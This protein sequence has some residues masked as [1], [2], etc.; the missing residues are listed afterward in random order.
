MPSH[1]DDAMKP[2]MPSLSRRQLLK[3]GVATGLTLLAPP[4]LASEQPKLTIPPLLDVGRGRPIRLDF[5]LT[6]TRLT[7]GKFTDVW[8]ANGQYL[9]PTVRVKSG[10]FLKLT[11]LNNLNQPI[12]MNLQGLFAPTDIIGSAHREL[13]VKSSWSPIVSINQSASTGW[14]HADTMQKSA[15][16]LYRGLAGMLWI[17]DEQSKQTKLPN[18]YGVNDIPLI[19]QDLQLN[20]EGVQVINPEQPFFGKQLLVNGQAAPY[21]SVA[22][23]WVRLRIVNASLSRP[24]DLQL[25]NGKPLHWIGTGVG[26]FAEPIEMPSLRLAPSERAEILVE[27][28][29][30]KEINL[31]SGKKRNLL[32]DIQRFFRPNNEL[33]NNVILTLRLEGLVSLFNERPVLPAFDESQFHLSIQQERK[34]SLNTQNFTINQQKFDAQRI[35]FEAKK[36]S[37]ER[38][39]LTADRDVG[40]TLQGAKFL[41]ETRDRKPLSKKWLVWRDTVWLTKGQE[42]TILVKFEQ[43]ASASLPFS[44]GAS[45]FLL[46]DKGVMGQFSVTE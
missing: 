34:L 42:A 21:L 28:N 13:A 41:L 35:D 4:V 45:D 11:Y 36:G 2:T 24:Y 20:D 14:Y 7:A 9:A 44:F 23:G 18:R 27:L 3:S 46:R 6:Q 39:Y 29:E 43:T 31:L 38:W 17:D 40:F 37:V 30:G 15:L 8:G 1:K 10:D 22:R 16:Q 19:L 33:D 25:D 32:D 12:S 5:R 26:M